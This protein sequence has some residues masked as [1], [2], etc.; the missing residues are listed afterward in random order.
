MSLSLQTSTDLTLL[1]LTSKDPVYY[2]SSEIVDLNKQGA[3]NLRDSTVDASGPE[4]IV[5]GKNEKSPGVVKR[6]L[7]L[8]IGWLKRLI[9]F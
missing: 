7:S 2:S 5:A 1:D 9:G 3:D 6:F 8:T 4:T